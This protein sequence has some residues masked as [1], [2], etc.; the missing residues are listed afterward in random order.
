M[1]QNHNSDKT[2]NSGLIHK[3]D[4]IDWL[5]IGL[6]IWLMIYPHP[7]ELVFTAVLF[8]P[9]IGLIYHGHSKPA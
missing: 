4:F 5:T 6:C 3:F 1:G 8:L 2:K 9:I 7:Y